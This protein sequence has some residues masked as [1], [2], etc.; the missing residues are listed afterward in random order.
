MKKR[1]AIFQ[2][3]KSKYWQLTHTF[4]IKIPKS[5]PE[6]LKI[7]R[8]NGNHLWRYPINKKITNIRNAV[9]EYCET[10]I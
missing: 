10:L 1:K 9:D 7:N 3:V 2:K 4:G 6:A 8:Q 5:V